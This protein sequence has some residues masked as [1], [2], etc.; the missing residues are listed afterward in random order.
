VLLS[1]HR[2]GGT[3]ASYARLRALLAEDLQQI[4]AGLPPLRLQRA[5]PAL[6]SRDRSR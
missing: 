5:E 2:A 6:A 3:E 4:R 1:A